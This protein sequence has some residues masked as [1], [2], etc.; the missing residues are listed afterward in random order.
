[1]F[2]KA[3][4]PRINIYNFA[5]NN[6]IYDPTNKNTFY[7][8]SMLNNQAY[9]FKASSVNTDTAMGMPYLH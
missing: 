1:M 6:R 8:P 7:D 9:C 4:L 5:L 3:S 2:N